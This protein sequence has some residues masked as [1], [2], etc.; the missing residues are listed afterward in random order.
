MAF[1][2]PPNAYVMRGVHLAFAL[3]LAYLILPGLRQR[4][5]TFGWFDLAFV[6]EDSVQADRL[7]RALRTAAGGL[8]VDC[9]LFDVYRGAGVPDGAR[10]LAWRLRLQAADRSLDDTDIATVRDACAT[11]AAALGAQ[12]RG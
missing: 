10:S 1:A 7:E 11:A 5:E 12:L 3:V 4:R 2:G 8:L 6:L 9:R